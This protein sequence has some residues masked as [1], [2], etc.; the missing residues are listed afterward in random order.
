MGNLPPV[1]SLRHPVRE[2]NSPN[3]NILVGGGK[4]IN[5]DSLSNGE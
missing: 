5:R 1:N 3:G 2:G 4:E